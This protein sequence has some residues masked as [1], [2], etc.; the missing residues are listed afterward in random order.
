MKSRTK[1]FIRLLQRDSVPAFPSA[2]SNGIAPLAIAPFGK[3]QEYRTCDPCFADDI[4]NA[5]ERL[6]KYFESPSSRKND[7]SER[8]NCL[9]MGPPGAG[10]TFVAKTLCSGLGDTEFLEFNVADFG[11]PEGANT[12]FDHIRRS[13]TRKKTVVFVDEFDV[14]IGGSSFIRYLINPI[15]S[16]EYFNSN[17]SKEELGKV[18]FLFSGS[19][20]R[21]KYV[22]S[23]LLH[24]VADFDLTRF[25]FDVYNSLPSNYANERSTVREQ[26]D[27]AMKYREAR[28]ATEA[29]QDV[30]DYLR[31]LDKLRDFLSRINGF[32]LEL[33]DTSDP[34]RVTD[35]PLALVR[36]FQSEIS[37]GDDANLGCGMTWRKLSAQRHAAFGDNAEEQPQNRPPELKLSR[38]ELAPA[39]VAFVQATAKTPRRSKGTDKQLTSRFR[40][41]DHPTD[42]IL[43][44][45]NM[46]LLERLTRI[47]VLLRKKHG[48]QNLSIRRDTLAYLSMVRL[49]HG[50]RSLEVLLGYL[51]PVSESDPVWVLDSGAHQNDI[52]RMHINDPYGSPE[53]LWHR[54]S[55]VNGSGFS[56]IAAK[57][58]KPIEIK[59]DPKKP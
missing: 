53:N 24:H 46:L 7:K 43:E 11:S 48:N 28:S 37:L 14:T 23:T 13:A 20:L 58:Q 33:P 36:N 32:I 51:K 8:L 41:F 26:L 30:L 47:L 54:L 16:G 55:A 21:S 29:D 6:R 9:I 12:M 34:L 49:E 42:A 27:L 40:Q 44:Y 59:F 56:A 5:A 4:T 35:E 52:F 22:L 57:Q 1:S 18:A 15:Y 10:K 25:L 50:V 45:K 39:V 38:T 19:Y 17:G 31:R 2:W 3:K